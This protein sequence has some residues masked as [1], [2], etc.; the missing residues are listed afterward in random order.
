[1]VTGL[2]TVHQHSS[3]KGDQRYCAPEVGQGVVYNHKIDVYN[4]LHS[5]SYYNW[6]YPHIPGPHWTERPECSQRL[7]VFYKCAFN[8]LFRD[9]PTHPEVSHHQKLSAYVLGIISTIHALIAGYV[10]CSA[11]WFRSKSWTQIQVLTNTLVIP[12]LVL[13]YAFKRFRVDKI[14]ECVQYL[15]ELNPPVIHR[16][17]KPDNI[18]LAK[19]YVTGLATVH[20]HSSDKGD[21]RYCAPEVGQGVVYNHKIDVYSLAKI[22]EKDIFG[23]HLEDKPLQKYSNNEMYC[24]QCHTITG[25]TRTYPALTGQKGPSAHKS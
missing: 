7:F 17:L 25:I 21:Q 8:Q 23:I 15:H 20:Q 24:I 19:T 18:L 6:D 12:F 2:A 9:K 3:D 16:D 10:G 13:A 5:M 22:A 11:V 1:Y 14:L 4:V